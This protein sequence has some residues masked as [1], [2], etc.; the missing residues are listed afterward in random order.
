MVSFRL[1]SM[2]KGSLHARFS[3][4]K[5]ERGHAQYQAMPSLRD[6]AHDGVLC[7]FSNR[8]AP[9]RAKWCGPSG[10]VAWTVNH[11][12]NHHP[13]GSLSSSQPGGPP[14]WTSPLAFGLIGHNI[15][16]QPAH[17]TRLDDLSVSQT[18]LTF[19]PKHAPRHLS[20]LSKFNVY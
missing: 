2:H 1:C 7:T 6:V 12:Q 20:Y 8:S 15:F 4:L 18:F 10:Q 11:V 14:C 5:P 16:F 17:S 9:D 19:Q 3:Q 13:A